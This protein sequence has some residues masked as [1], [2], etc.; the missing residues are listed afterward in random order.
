M[1]KLFDVKNAVKKA[2]A[3][4]CMT[5]GTGCLLVLT[6]FAAPVSS[7][8]IVIHTSKLEQVEK[9]EWKNQ[10]A[11]EFLRGYK[12]I[13]AD[14]DDVIESLVHRMFIK[15]YL[16][17]ENGNHIVL[18]IEDPDAT[19]KTLDRLNQGLDSYLW[20]QE[21][22][23]DL[24]RGYLENQKSRPEYRGQTS[25]EVWKTIE[26]LLDKSENVTSAEMEK[27]KASDLIAYVRACGI[28][29]TQLEKELAEI[30]SRYQDNENFRELEKRMNAVNDKYD[31]DEK[32][33]WDDF[34]DKS[35]INNGQNHDHRYDDDRYDRDDDDRYDRDDDDRFD[36]DDDWDDDD[37][38]DDD[39]DDWDDDRY[40]D[41]DD[42]YDDDRYDHDHDDDHDDD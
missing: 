29:T 26:K 17:Q 6:A 14:L 39:D 25:K 9:L 27:V 13:D 40:G 20:Q 3:G 31:A 5:A 21:E 42:R 32:E 1:K 30:D 8:D 34:Y 36:D 10:E 19:D 41:D 24:F 18:A 4:V 15:G 35:N 38:Y 2:A 11:R 22:R 28:S 23:V 12:I 7:P 37:R 16:D 33:R